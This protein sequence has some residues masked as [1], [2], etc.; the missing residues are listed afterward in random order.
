MLVGIP[1]LCHF[2]ENCLACLFGADDHNSGVAPVPNSYLLFYPLRP[3]IFHIIERVFFR[4]N[5]SDLEQLYN[6][7][8]KIMNTDEFSKEYRNQQLEKNKKISDHSHTKSN[9]SFK[10]EKKSKKTYS[11][12]NQFDEK[13]WKFDTDY[14]DHFETPL[15]AY[16]DIYNTIVEIAK[17]LKKP[18]RD[19]VIYDPYYCKGST[20]ILINRV[21]QMILPNEN[22]TIKVINENR[23]FYQDIKK[24]KVPQY[25]IL[26]TNP[27][28][29]GDHK[30]KL[31][32][33]IASTKEHSE[34]NLMKPFL[35]LLPLYTCTKSY[36]KEFVQNHSSMSTYYILPPDHYCVSLLCL[37]TIYVM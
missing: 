13:Y 12:P 7:M 18:L 2:V 19:L 6:N 24:N 31:L 3:F 27:P 35:L 36:W 9:Q 32:N 25:D 21:F 34:N 29:S 26:I 20:S 16:I 4:P 28:Y 11:K 33:Y 30:S 15:V 37:Y 23:D 14:N 17:I 5:M 10:N 22:I 1:P 8:D